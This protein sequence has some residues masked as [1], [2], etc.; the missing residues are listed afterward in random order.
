[1]AK[2]KDNLQFELYFSYDEDEEEYRIEVYEDE[3]LESVFEGS[4][5]GD[6]L[7]HALHDYD[8][9]LAAAAWTKDYFEW[10]EKHSMGEDD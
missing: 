2:T 1:M 7:R 5:F 8:P 3:S 10:S 6:V 4:N 9:V